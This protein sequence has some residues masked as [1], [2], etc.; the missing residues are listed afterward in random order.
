[1]NSK[2]I[3]VNASTSFFLKLKNIIDPEK[4]R[5]V[6]GKEFIKIF[7]KEAKKI[8]N[9]KFLAQGTLYPDVIESKKIDGSNAN[10]I[11]S[12]HNVG[13]LPKNLNLRLLEPLRELFKDEV[14]LLGKE[15]GLPKDII[16]RHPFPGPGLS[17]RIP[18]EITKNKINI[19]KMADKIY[20]EELLTNNLYNKIWQAF[21]VLLPVKSVGVMG[22][23][24]SYE[25][26]ISIRAI[27]S[28]D[29]MTADIYYFKEKFLKK[30]SGRIIGEVQGVNR[31]LFDITSKPPATIEWE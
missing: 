5:K 1:M 21:C 24:R 9:A 2:L 29:G 7:E 14:R 8:K 28:T 18:G 25:Y 22:D 19:L 13:G 11:K 27:T 30:L 4:K 26:T 16:H 31:V 12:H 3:Y 17:I 23:S 15:L 6:I 20:I 10:V